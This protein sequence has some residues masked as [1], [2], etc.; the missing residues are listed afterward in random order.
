[1]SGP[2]GHG[3]VRRKYVTEKSGDTTGNQS[4]DRPTSSAALNDY[5]TSGPFRTLYTIQTEPLFYT[6]WGQMLASQPEEWQTQCRWRCTRQKEGRKEQNH[7]KRQDGGK[8][9]LSISVS[10]PQKT[11]VTGG[12]LPTKLQSYQLWNINCVFHADSQQ[13]ENPLLTHLLQ[14]K[15]INQFLHTCIRCPTVMPTVWTWW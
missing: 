8:K 4:R 3:T 5:A 1:M 14:V 9:Q 6:L 12:T 11:A 2:Q 7:G 15:Y 13:T 10:A